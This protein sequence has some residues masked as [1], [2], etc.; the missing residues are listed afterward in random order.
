MIKKE[1]HLNFKSFLIWISIIISMYIIV[2]AI[3][4]SMTQDAEM[5]NQ[6][7]ST[8][9]KEML[10][11][12]NMDVVGIE[13]VFGWI[14]TE[15]FMMMTLVGGVFFALMGSNILLKEENDGTIEFLYSKPITR[16]EIL[17]S[18]FITGLVYIGLFNLC[19]SI[20]V[21]FGLIFSKDLNFVKWLLISILPIVIHLFFFSV[22]FFIS[23]FLTKTRKSVG[24]SLGLLFGFYLL[25]VLG[26]MS[27][28]IEFLKYFSPFYYINARSI[29]T[30]T[31]IDVL[32]CMIVLIAAL[33]FTLLSFKFF[34]KKELI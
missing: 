2:F 11:H 1:I 4:P 30:D 28:K 21:L 32:N 15:G 8:F 14:A 33:I 20:V 23:I 17:I 9:P 29:I 10:E 24:I 27:E 34:D 7:L 13:T 18:K 19:I 12:F 3:Y 22:S 25:N 16:R 6:L 5:M 26:S 31:K